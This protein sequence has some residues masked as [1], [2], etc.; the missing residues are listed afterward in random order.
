MKEIESGHYDG[1]VINYSFSPS[2]AEVEIHFWDWQPNVTSQS[3]KR[4]ILEVSA[5]NP[6]AFSISW[7]SAVDISFDPRDH[8]VWDFEPKS[9]LVLYRSIDFD[10][11]FSELEKRLSWKKDK[12]EKYFDLTNSAPNKGYLPYSIYNECVKVL[13]INEEPKSNGGYEKLKTL[14]FDSNYLIA[15]E[16][17]FRIRSR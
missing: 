3:E 14:K 17:V 9:S 2:K 11:L 12:F 10:F 15:E 7:K 5:A 6:F 8:L 4:S 16:F 1:E 13:G